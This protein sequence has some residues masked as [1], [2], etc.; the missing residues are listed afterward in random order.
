MRGVVEQRHLLASAAEQLRDPGIGRVYRLLRRGG[1]LVP[2][3]LGLQ[4]QMVGHRV[5]RRLRQ[6]RRSGVVQV[7]PKGA[8]RGEGTQGVNIHPT[9]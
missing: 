1:G 2:A 9:P 8:S 3:D 5:Q 6:Q 7:H 4:R